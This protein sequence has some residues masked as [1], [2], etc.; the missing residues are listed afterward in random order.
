MWGFKNYNIC[1]YS[2]YQICTKNFLIR[3]WIH[4]FLVSPGPVDSAGF[5]LDP[6]IF[7]TLKVACLVSPMAMWRRIPRVRSGSSSVGRVRR[8]AAGILWGLTWWP[9]NKGCRHNTWNLLFYYIHT[10]SFL[11]DNINHLPFR[12]SWLYE[13]GTPCIQNCRLCPQLHLGCKM[14]FGRGPHFPN[15]SICPRLLL[16]FLYVRMNQHFAARP[17]CILKLDLPLLLSHTNGSKFNYAWRSLSR[18]GGQRTNGGQNGGF[19]LPF[20]SLRFL[21]HKNL[22]LRNQH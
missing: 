7:L 11:V 9:S 22:W 2:F 14:T 10:I 4:G 20:L 5:H 21:N 15:A 18:S 17:G 12:V 13:R 8:S 16:E 6:T 3:N 1:I 19:S